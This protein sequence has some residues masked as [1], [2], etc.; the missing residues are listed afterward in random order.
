MWKKNRDSEVTDWKAVAEDMQFFLPSDK[1]LEDFVETRT[2]I[3][4]GSRV[5]RP[6]W[7]K[8]E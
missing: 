1:K 6:F 3:K 8:E 5:F 4:P 2:T 7:K